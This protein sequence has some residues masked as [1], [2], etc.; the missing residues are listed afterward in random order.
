MAKELGDITHI[1]SWYRSESDP[2]VPVKYGFDGFEV[3]VIDI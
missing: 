3:K 2:D 1:V